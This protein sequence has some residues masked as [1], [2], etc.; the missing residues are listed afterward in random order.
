MKRTVSVEHA[1]Q[2]GQ[3]ARSDMAHL[4]QH[5]NAH[6]SCKWR[7]CNNGSAKQRKSAE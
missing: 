7:L 1:S 2:I 3:R 6:G 4:A 5:R